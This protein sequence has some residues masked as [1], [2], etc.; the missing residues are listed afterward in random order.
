MKVVITLKDN[1]LKTTN[2]KGKEY[3]EVNER[4]KYFRNRFPNYALT[5]ELVSI[6]D[7]LCI[8]KASVLNADNRVV[9]TGTAYEK[10]GS[11][12][13]NKTSYIENCETSA[14]GRAL[15]FFGIGI[16][17]SVASADEVLNAQLNQGA[18]SVPTLKSGEKV[19]LKSVRESV[20]KSKQK[21]NQETALEKEI[22]KARDDFKYKAG[23]ITEEQFI[24]LFTVCKTDKEVAKRVVEMLENMKLKKI[25][26]LTEDRAKTV[27]SII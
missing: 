7:E 16:D 19:S 6:T 26:E 12:Y 18:E 17:T 5:T 24:K 20:T 21:V 22:K 1:N 9:S 27:I 14:V 3:V 11:S 2:I 25:Q 15:G 10:E 8:F 4:V 23:Y 13:I